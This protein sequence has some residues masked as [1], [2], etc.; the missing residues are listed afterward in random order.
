LTFLP[1]QT[2]VSNRQTTPAEIQKR[3]KDNNMKIKVNSIQRSTKA[4]RLADATVD[5]WD[6]TG[7]SLIISD[8]RI[9]QNR[10]G[11]LW[12]AMPSRSVADGGRS[13]QYL[14]QVE[15]S[16]LLGRKIEDSVLAAFEQ[17]KV[18]N[19]ETEVPA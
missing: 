10:Q 15:S 16:K 9:L 19:S 7:D 8:I 12:V 2:Y 18:S 6:E 5:L 14:P 1:L 17:W 13:F 11:Q 3:N 4:N